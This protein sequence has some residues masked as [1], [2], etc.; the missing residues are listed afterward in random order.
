MLLLPASAQKASNKIYSLIAPSSFVWRG[1]VKNET[2]YSTPKGRFELKTN[3]LLKPSGKYICALLSCWVH[4]HAA[5]N[6]RMGSHELLPYP[7]YNLQTPELAHYNILSTEKTQTV[8][9]TETYT[10]MWELYKPSKMPPLATSHCPW[11]LCTVGWAWH[12]ILWSLH[13]CLLFS[14]HPKTPLDWIYVAVLS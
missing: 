13:A 11:Q 2:P 5:Q 3:D 8:S 9:A 7:S 14:S 4:S 12:F 6:E 1:L 10:E